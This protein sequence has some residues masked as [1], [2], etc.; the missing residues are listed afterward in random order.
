MV[1]L[2]LVLCLDARTG[3]NIHIQYI[4]HK[5][6]TRMKLI[7]GKQVIRTWTCRVALHSSIWLGV[8]QTHTF[9]RHS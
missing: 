6:I 5:C 1:V 9:V 4:D 7:C 2:L 8:C 3:D